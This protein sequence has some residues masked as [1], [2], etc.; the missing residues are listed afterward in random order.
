MYRKLETFLVTSKRFMYAFWD[1]VWIP[2]ILVVTLMMEG[3]AVVQLLEA[4]R[5][6]SEG[7]G[8]DSR[9]C[10]WN[11]SLTYSFQ[12]HYG[13][14][15]DSASNRNEYQ[16]YILGG[17]GGRCVRLTTLPPSWAECLEIWE[18]QHPGTLWACT[19]I[20]FYPDD[21]RDGDCNMYY[22]INKFYIPQL[23]ILLHEFKYPS[24]PQQIW[25]IWSW[26]N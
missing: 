5:Y 17:E 15:V 18:P 24:N 22:V 9:W 12:S 4:L 26:Q 16:E 8:F 14:G 11:L 2:N 3:H 21:D 1:F 6:K 13:P 19:E 23:F 20:A 7:H 10:Y 25:N